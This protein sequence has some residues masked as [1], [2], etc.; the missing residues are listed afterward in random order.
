MQCACG[1]L[2]CEC[3]RQDKG[4]LMSECERQDPCSV[5]VMC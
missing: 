4:V 5:S 1:V 3:E 2:M